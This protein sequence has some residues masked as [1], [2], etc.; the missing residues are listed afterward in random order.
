M[1]QAAELKWQD[2]FLKNVDLAAAAAAA[3]VDAQMTM[4]RE[5]RRVAKNQQG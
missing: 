4:E 1:S 3:A 5:K 2:G